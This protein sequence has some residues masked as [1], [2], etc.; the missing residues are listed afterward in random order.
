MTTFSA[1]TR[2]EAVVDAPRHRIWAALT[3]PD[4]VAELTPF[5]RTIR[6]DGEHWRWEMSG[7]KVLG[8]GVAPSF[9]ERMTYDEP[10]RIEFRHDPPAGAT[11]RSSVEGWYSLDEHRAGTRLVTS[12]EISLDLPLPRASGRAVRATMNRVID[13]MGDRFS[14]NLLAHLG[15]REVA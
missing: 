8:V 15:A 10:E 3:D 2:A 14:R 13:Q 5:V 9:T 6:E 1:D 12:L 4:L 11:E 7:L